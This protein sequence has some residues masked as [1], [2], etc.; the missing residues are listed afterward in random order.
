MSAALFD[1]SRTTIRPAQ[2]VR[3]IHIEVFQHIDSPELLT[4]PTGEAACRKDEKERTKSPFHYNFNLASEVLGRDYISSRILS[5][6]IKNWVSFDFNVAYS[7][8]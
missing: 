1:L 3:S 6:L 5:R 8:C 4:I 7:S 2:K